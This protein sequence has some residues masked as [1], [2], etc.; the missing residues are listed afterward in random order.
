MT[1]L[2]VTD[3]SAYIQAATM[4]VTFGRVAIDEIRTMFGANQNLT[5]EEL[6]IIIDAV[7]SDAERRKALADAE[8][9]RL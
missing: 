8:S 1:R 2:S 3:L 5:A 4:L 6:N 7:Q 9:G